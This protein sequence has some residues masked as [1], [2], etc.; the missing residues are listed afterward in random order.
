[1]KIL[2]RK[3]FPEILL[4]F[5]DGPKSFNDLQ[6][7]FE[8]NPSTLS[9]RINDLKQLNLIEPIVIKRQNRSIIQYQ[10]TNKGK[11]ILANVL[12]LLELAKE[13]EKYLT[14]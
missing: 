11:R 5:K 2:N 3:Y 14:S 1:M 4:A 10:L 9:R 12:Q 7:A 8:V 6:R 13:I